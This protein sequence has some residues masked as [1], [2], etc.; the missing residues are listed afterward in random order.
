MKMGGP[1]ISMGP[2]IILK[3]DVARELAEVAARMAELRAELLR[4]GTKLVDLAEKVDLMIKLGVEN[5][6][7][8]DWKP[9]LATEK[10]SSALAETVLDIVNLRRWLIGKGDPK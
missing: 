7:V 5:M 10:E 3:A 2:P 8:D 6:V 1:R 4:S 9:M